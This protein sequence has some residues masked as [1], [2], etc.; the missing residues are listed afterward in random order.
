MSVLTVRISEK[1]KTA[2]AARAKS[3]GTTTGALVRRMIQ[4]QPFTTAADLLADIQTRMGD[5]RLVIRRR[6]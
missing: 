5:K 2:L 6:S 1:E 4:E 3:E